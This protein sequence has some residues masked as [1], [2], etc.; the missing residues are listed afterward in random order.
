MDKILRLF[1]A[2]AVLATKGQIEYLKSFF[3]KEL[4]EA[5]IRSSYDG[6]AWPYVREYVAA[7][8]A[9]VS[10]SSGLAFVD[11]IH[12]ELVEERTIE[13]KMPSKVKGDYW[14]NRGRKCSW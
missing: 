14:N 9:L 13:F 11:G 8:D 2:H 5:M 7:F 3:G 6:P 12:K 1:K 4:I 10:G